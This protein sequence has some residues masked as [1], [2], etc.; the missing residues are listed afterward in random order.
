MTHLA[1]RRALLFACTIGGVLLAFW[2]FQLIVSW[3]GASVSSDMVLASV[4]LPQTIAVLANYV[5]SNASVPVLAALS[6]EDRRRTS[7][8]IFFRFAVWSLPLLALAWATT[9][10]W[11]PV[12][13][14][15]L[16]AG[17]NEVD[18][19]Q[20]IHIQIVGS[21]FIA[22]SCVL[23]SLLKSRGEVLKGEIS[24]L[25][26]NASVIAM[27]LALA[28]R[29]GL[30][31]VVTAM[32]CKYAIQTLC[33][34][35]FAGRP[36]RQGSDPRWLHDIN[37][38]MLTLLKGAAIL[39]LTL[40]AER[41]IASLAPPGG[42][43]LFL[44]AQ[45]CIGAVEQ[46]ISRTIVTT[47]LPQLSRAWAERRATDFR[48]LVRRDVTRVVVATLI[49][50]ATI[51]FAGEPLL[52]LAF[53][54]GQFS[55]QDVSTLH[56]LVCL[57]VG[58]LVVSPTASLLNNAFY[59]TGL[60]KTPLVIGASAAVIGMGLRYLGVTHFGINGLVLAVTAQYLIAVCA[61]IPAYRR[62][63]RHPSWTERT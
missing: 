21:W 53:E 46:V 47:A 56:L 51:Y 8:H 55:G 59:S 40:P 28:D 9:E 2:Q 18:L 22:P 5:I 6:Q 14:A 31:G 13:F 61:L 60:V 43:T 62:L 58:Q 29:Y 42:L 35:L 52:R 23:W 3:Y 36:L 30:A 10:A 57:L 37:R 63:A 44:L 4:V 19:V 1:A 48:H 25:V 16:A 20:L 32:A 15:K 7:W 39:K 26:G 12:A 17:D 50:W 54:S 24:Y 27:M 49:I 38:R 45:Q 41:I 33:L 34:T 11:A